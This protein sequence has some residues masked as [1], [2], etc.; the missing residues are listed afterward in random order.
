MLPAEPPRRAHSQ[1]DLRMRTANFISQVGSRVN[2][3]GSRVSSIG[4]DLM[5][6][7]RSLERFG[8]E[9]ALSQASVFSETQ[10]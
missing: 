3:I 2:S 5:N 8:S 7:G 10:F 4:S 6:L 1:S 9:M